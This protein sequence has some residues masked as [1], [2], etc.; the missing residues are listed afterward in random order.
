[1]DLNTSVRFVLN[2][3]GA[4]CTNILVDYLNA[5]PQARDE[6][7]RYQEK[8]LS[9]VT[10][11]EVM[12]GTTATTEKKTKTFL[13]SFHLIKLDDLV[14]DQAVMLRKHYRIKL[15]DA[16]IWASAQINAMLLI[17]RNTKDFNEKEPGIRVPYQL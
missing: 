7:G 12:V 16:V 13:N 5:V 9:V 1:M 17:T 10:W 11:M 2:G 15:P 14:A 6:L 4:F 3:K 8:A